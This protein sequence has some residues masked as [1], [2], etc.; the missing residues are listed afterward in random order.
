MNDTVK[1]CVFLPGRK[2]VWRSRH[3]LTVAIVIRG[4]TFYRPVGQTENTGTYAARYSDSLWES[5]GR[6][7]FIDRRVAGNAEKK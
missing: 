5:S 2:I 4:I 7:E 6:V 3:F 1:A